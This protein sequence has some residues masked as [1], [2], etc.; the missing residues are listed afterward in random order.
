[1]LW[2]LSLPT[3]INPAGWSFEFPTPLVGTANTLL[4]VVTLTANVTGAI[5]VNVQGYAAR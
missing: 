3:T 2:R 1:M 5:Y 4:E